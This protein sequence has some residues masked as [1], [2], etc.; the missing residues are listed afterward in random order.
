MNTKIDVKELYQEKAEDIAEGEYGD[1]F[2]NLP[3]ETRLAIY[4]RAIDIVHDN[5]ITEADLRG[6]LL[7]MDEL[8]NYEQEVKDNE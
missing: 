5:L 1:S 2:Y 6:D 3:Q 4:S 7:I 8:A